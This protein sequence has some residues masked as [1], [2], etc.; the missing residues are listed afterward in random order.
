MWMHHILHH[1]GV[2]IERSQVILVESGELGQLRH[3]EHL[4]V[5]IHEL[6]GIKHILG[7]VGVL[8][9]GEGLESRI[10]IHREEGRVHLGVELLL[11]EEVLHL[12]G[13]GV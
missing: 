12:L 6:L 10:V 9:V 8:H 5:G 2:R 1:H 11:Q 4:R 3:I 7:E 13:S